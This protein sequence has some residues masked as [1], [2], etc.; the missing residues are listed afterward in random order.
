VVDERLTDVLAGLD[1]GELP[2]A[3]HHHI[4]RDILDVLVDPPEVALWPRPH[5]VTG[6]ASL[7]ASQSCSG[8]RLCVRVPDFGVLCGGSG[9]WD[10]E[11][12]GACEVVVVDQDVGCEVG[13]HLR[14]V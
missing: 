2:K 7:L 8:R 12:L 5:L 13:M 11:Q 6:S 4:D 1:L 9:W 14:H 3:V 10:S